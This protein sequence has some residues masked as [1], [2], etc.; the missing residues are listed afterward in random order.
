MFVVT[1]WF[2]T[3]C[4]CSTRHIAKVRGYK[5]SQNGTI[6]AREDTTRSICA[7]FGRGARNGSRRGGGRSSLR[8]GRDRHTRWAPGV[9]AN[10]LRGRD[11][12]Y[13]K[14]IALSSAI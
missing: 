5:Q 10:E 1:F 13:W 3:G 9:Q 6:R 2:N 14:Y 8:R 11:K 12:P 7:V 4:D